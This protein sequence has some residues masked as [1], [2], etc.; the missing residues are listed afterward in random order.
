M[1]AASRAE[2][3]IVLHPSTTSNQQASEAA[4]AVTAMALS[5]TASRH[6]QSV[7]MQM[8]DELPGALDYMKSFGKAASTCCSSGCGAH[9]R[10]AQQP[11]QPP[12]NANMNTIPTATMVLGNLNGSTLQVVQMPD[13]E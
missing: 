10:L 11:Q 1:V 8:P 9:A 7:V 5:V 3:V 12:R 2:T 4:K 13:G 6:H